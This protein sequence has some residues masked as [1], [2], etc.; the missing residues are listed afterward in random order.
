MTTNPKPPWFR[1]HLLTAVVMMV[2]AGGWLLL[3]LQ[4]TTNRQELQ[5]ST[6]EFGIV[7]CYIDWTHRG[8]PFVY[9]QHSPKISEDALRRIT[10]RPPNFLKTLGNSPSTWIALN[11][12][13]GIVVLLAVLAISES[14]LRRREAR[15]P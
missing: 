7:P 8:F 1:F 5:I 2:A 6:P 9:S 14:F 10:G 15:K 4:A 13:A 3:N 12:V 11:A